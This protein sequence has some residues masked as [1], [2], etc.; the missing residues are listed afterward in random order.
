MGKNRKKNDNSANPMKEYCHAAEHCRMQEE[1]TAPP[2]YLLA[3][4]LK[5]RKGQKQWQ[6]TF[7]DCKWYDDRSTKKLRMEECMGA[8]HCGWENDLGKCISLPQE[9]WGTH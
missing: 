1:G 2:S 3:R 8:K 6:C 7:K 9:E 4:K 5:P